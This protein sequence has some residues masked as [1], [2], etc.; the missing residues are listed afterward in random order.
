ML[1]AKLDLEVA[2]R[3]EGAAIEAGGKGRRLD[4][5]VIGVNGQARYAQDRQAPGKARAC[6]GLDSRRSGRTPRRRRTA[7]AQTRHK[8]RPYS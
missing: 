3:L 1:K 6:A 7:Q 2:P 8:T 4:V 5:K